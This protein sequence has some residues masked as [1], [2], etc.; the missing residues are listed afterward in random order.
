MP[1]KPA[2]ITVRMTPELHERLKQ[3]AAAEA[4]RRHDP[5]FSMNRFCLEA[6]ETHEQRLAIDGGMLDFPR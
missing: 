1:E 6:L 5:D 4:V 3:R 2:V